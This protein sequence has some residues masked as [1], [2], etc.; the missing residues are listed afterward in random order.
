MART[1][2]NA[3]ATSRRIMGSSELSWTAISDRN[4]GCLIHRVSGM[5]ACEYQWE[6][7]VCF[8]YSLSSRLIMLKAQRLRGS[9]AALRSVSKAFLLLLGNSL[10]GRGVDVTL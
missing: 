6:K 8:A 5:D 7:R 10:G 9:Q 3:S 4:V 2:L 1:V